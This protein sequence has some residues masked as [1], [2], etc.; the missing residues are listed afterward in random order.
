MYVSRSWVLRCHCSLWRCS[1]I[2]NGLCFNCQTFSFSLSPFCFVYTKRAL[3]DKWI[4]ALWDIETMNE[5]SSYRFMGLRDSRTDCL[6]SPPPDRDRN[7][8]WWCQEDLFSV[9][10]M[11]EAAAWWVLWS[12]VLREHVG[13]FNFSPRLEATRNCKISLVVGTSSNRV[14]GMGDIG[15]KFRSVTHFKFSGSMTLS[16]ISLSIAVRARLICLIRKMS[17]VQYVKLDLFNSLVQ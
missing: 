4:D 11:T 7:G 10:G 2:F 13:Q 6:Q 5:M 1:D 16:L 3:Y 15:L 14:Y 12:G 9:D 17:L 8:V